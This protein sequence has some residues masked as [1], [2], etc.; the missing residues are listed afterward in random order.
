MKFGSLYGSL[1]RHWYAPGGAQWAPHYDFV[2]RTTPTPVV[3]TAVVAV[4]A[5]DRITVARLLVAD[6]IGAARESAAV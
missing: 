5:V 1:I 3:G 2:L 6:R 4:I